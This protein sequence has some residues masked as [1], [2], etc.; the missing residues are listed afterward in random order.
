MGL[1]LNFRRLYMNAKWYA[2]AP[3]RPMMMT[4]SYYVIVYGGFGLNLYVCVCVSVHQR[5]IEAV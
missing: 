1:V 3:K 2:A 4:T 5:T